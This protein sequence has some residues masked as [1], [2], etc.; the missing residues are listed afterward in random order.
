MGSIEDR[1]AKL[2]FADYFA[3][4]PIQMGMIVALAKVFGFELDESVA[5]TITKRQLSI[6]HGISS[7][8]PVV[9]LILE[10]PL[11]LKQ[12]LQLQ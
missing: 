8:V 6:H 7:F 3:I 2:P 4:I 11:M 9:F 10:M 12:L 5:E 1:I